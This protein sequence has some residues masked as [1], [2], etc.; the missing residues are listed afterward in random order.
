MSY[1]TPY[2]YSLCGFEVKDNRAHRASLD[3]ILK[4]VGLC[5]SSFLYNKKYFYIWIDMIKFRKLLF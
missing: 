5:S 3:L 1:A 4:E 2:Q